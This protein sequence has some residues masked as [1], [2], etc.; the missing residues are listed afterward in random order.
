MYTNIY[1]QRISVGSLE[2]GGLTVHTF[3][4]AMFRVQISQNNDSEG[5][6]SGQI[7]PPT[8][9]QLTPKDAN[10]PRMPVEQED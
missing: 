2:K 1:S 4:W 5:S 3:F 8:V 6:I 7:S 9:S 10:R